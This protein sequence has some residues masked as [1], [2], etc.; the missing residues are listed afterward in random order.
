MFFDPAIIATLKLK[1]ATPKPHEG[2]HDTGDFQ[3]VPEEKRVMK[4]PVKQKHS[5]FQQLRGSRKVRQ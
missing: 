3:P 5:F 1:E 4:H 2:G